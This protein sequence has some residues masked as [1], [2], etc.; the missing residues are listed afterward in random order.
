MKI[1]KKPT[2]RTGRLRLPSG[3][4]FWHEGGQGETLVFLHGTWQDSLQWLPLLRRLSADF[5]CLAPDSLGFGESKS[6]PKHYSIQLQVEALAAFL[7]TL[8]VSRC[9]LI[10]HSLGAWVAVQFA[11]QY[12]DQVQGLVVIEPEGLEPTLDRSRWRLHRLLLNP[13]FMPIVRAAAPLIRLLGGQLW[14]TRAFALRQQLKTCPAACRTIFQRRSRELRGELV[15]DQ[16]AQLRM[17]VSV[18]VPEGPTPLHEVL[19]KAVIRALPTAQ[20]TSLPGGETAWE[21][22]L[23]PTEETVRAFVARSRLP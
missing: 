15:H 2:V 22:A 7:Q 16:L 18:L 3:T 13:L 9:Y 19:G 1:V 4:L 6:D 5:H 17:P 21:L 11:L 23:E 10:G 12:P 8:R 14:L 20:L